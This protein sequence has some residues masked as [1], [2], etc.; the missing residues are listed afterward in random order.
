MRNT[1]ES[2]RRLYPCG[3]ESNSGGQKMKSKLPNSSVP[4]DR[5]RSTPLRP[6]RTEADYDAALAEIE[7]YFD[8]EPEPGTAEADRFEVLATLIGAY[9]RQH[10][11][12][13]PPEPLDAIRNCMEQRGY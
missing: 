6:I 3:N 13:E 9:E 8:H 10:W 4:A 2:T 7:V 11:T 5:K 12:I 1:T